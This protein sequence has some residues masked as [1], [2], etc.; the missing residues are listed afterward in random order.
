MDHI[1]LI[2]VDTVFALPG[3]EIMATELFEMQENITD[4]D[5]SDFGKD[6][7]NHLKVKRSV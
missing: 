6:N 7:G 4:L 1:N 2:D 3:T 5:C